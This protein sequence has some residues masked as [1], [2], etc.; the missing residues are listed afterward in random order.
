MSASRVFGEELDARGIWWPRGDGDALR[1]LALA[2]K[3]T[4]DV[5]EDITAV[6]EQ[7]A[8][9][10]IEN[11][12][13]A[14]SDRFGAH[15]KAWSGDHG[16]LANTVADIRRLVAALT[17][18]GT[19]IDIADRTLARLVEQAIDETRRTP[20]PANTDVW[21]S[22]LH[23]CATAIGSNLDAAATRCSDGLSPIVEAQ[24]PVVGDV[25]LATIHASE[26]TWPDLGIPVDLSGITTAVVDFGAG[27]GR[28]PAELDPTAV[29]PPIT[30][31]VP[32]PVVSPPTTVVVIGDGNTVTVTPPP[33]TAL[34]PLPN[35]PPLP[36]LVPVPPLVTAPLPTLPGPSPVSTVTPQVDAVP[37]AAKKPPFGREPEKLVDVPLPIDRRTQEPAEGLGSGASGGRGFG[38]GTSLPSFEPFV[39]EPLPPLP[40]LDIAP[41]PTPTPTPSTPAAMPIVAA[42]GA[43]TAAVAAA[44]KKASN[45]GFFPM[46]PMAGGGSGDESPEPKRRSARR[47]RPPI[48]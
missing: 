8:L 22:W 21:M 1:D 41:L 29:L 48:S 6:L 2:W 24:P 20:T 40:P 23:D 12:H 43:A 13:G 39:P 3:V 32:A 45:N 19:D 16:Y 46:M 31:T 4:A 28:L 36:P 35:L 7:S 17:D 5:V 15:W 26:I 27:Q 47:P 38:G 44:G 37:S 14:A 18:F 11:Y 9:S 10:A 30:P 33:I 34:P 42:T 25:P